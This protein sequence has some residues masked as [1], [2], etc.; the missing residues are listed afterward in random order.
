VRVEANAVSVKLTDPFAHDRFR[1]SGPPDARNWFKVRTSET[2]G[3]KPSAPG[4]A[5]LDDNRQGQREQ[6]WPGRPTS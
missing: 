4:H 6:S 2:V 1:R 5:E 3:T